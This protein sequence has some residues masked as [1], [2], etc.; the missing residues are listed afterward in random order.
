[1]QAKEDTDLAEIPEDIAA[2]GVPES[3]VAEPEPDGHP[4]W[5]VTLYCMWVA[6]GLAILGFSFVMPFIPFYIRELGVTDPR[7][8]PIWAGLLVT[9]SGITMSVAS[10]V[11]GW[12]ADHYGR[13]A[14]V[15]RA[16]FGGAVL[17]SLMGAVK[18]VRQLLFLRILQGGVTGTA[19][20]SVALISSVVPAAYLGSSLGL[21]QMAVF[22]GSSLGPYVGGVM[23]EHL[24]YR[25]PFYFTGGLLFLAGLLV[26]FGARERFKRHVPADGSPPPRLREVLL[27][28]GVLTLLAVFALLN[29]SGSFVGPIFPLFVERVAGAPGRAA[30]Q[31]GLILAISGMTAALAAVMIGRVSDRLGYKPVLMVCTTLAGLLCFPQAAARSVGQLLVMRAVFGLAAGGMIPAMNALVATAVPR[32]S[33]GRA[34]GLTTTASA[35]GWASAPAIGGWMASVLGLRAPFVIMGGLYLALA[36]AEHWGVRSRAIR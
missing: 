9:G 30:E 31:T 24:G 25:L 35:L 13:K 15:Q 33:L 36:V 22:S 1:M 17:L 4:Q 29:F 7:L 19:P 5:R 26:L 20:A 34:Y 28:P 23:A 21:T 32:H 18:N 27:F 11:W 3:G 14:M 6:Q 2:V 10:P 16:M 8:L 12:V